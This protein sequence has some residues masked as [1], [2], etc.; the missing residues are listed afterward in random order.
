MV[1][2]E[3]SELLGQHLGSH[4]NGLSGA[5]IGNSVIQQNPQN[6]ADSLFIAVSLGVMIFDVQI[7]ADILL[8]CA[9]RKLLPSFDQ[10]SI[11]ISLPYIHFPVSRVTGSQSKHGLN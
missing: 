11:H 6:L 10:Q 4:F 5:G 9:F 7:Q 2:D 1:N 8:S 3:K